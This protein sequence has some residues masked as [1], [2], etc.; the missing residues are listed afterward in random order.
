VV[1]EDGKTYPA[2]RRRPR[3]RMPEKPAL[4]E[5]VALACQLA[6]DL[7]VPWAEVPEVHRPEARGVLEYLAD[8]V[9]LQL[10]AG[11]APPPAFD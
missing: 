8:A 10:A 1:G 11:D 2:R 3:P 4:P 6:Q 5:W 9:A 7:P